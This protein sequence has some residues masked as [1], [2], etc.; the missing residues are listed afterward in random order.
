MG[1][2]RERGWGKGL[3]FKTKENCEAAG[4][5]DRKGGDGEDLKRATVVVGENLKITGEAGCRFPH[6]SRIKPHQLQLFGRV[7]PGSANSAG[8]AI[9]RFGK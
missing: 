3:K 9:R 6:L 8:S 5:G 2:R 1:C 7:R 4:G